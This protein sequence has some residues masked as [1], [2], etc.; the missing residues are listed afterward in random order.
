MKVSVIVPV[1]NVEEYLCDCIDSVIN[2]TYKHFELILVDDGS[3]DGSGKICD[4][5]KIRHPDKI[6]VI[7]TQNLGPIQARMHGIR[8]SSGD[9]LVFLD[10]DDCLR[11]DTLEILVKC[12]VKQECDMVLYDAMICPAFPSKNIEY[13]FDNGI[14]FDK[15]SKEKLYEKLISRQIPNSVCL[16]AIR[17]NL[18]NLPDF[19]MHL[20]NVKHGEDLLMS[21]YFITNCEKI[22]YLKQGLYHYRVRPGS[23]VHS[24]NLQRAE[25]IKTVHTELEKC[26]DIWGLPELKP[27][28]NARK[29]K[30]WL[31]NFVLLL[32]NK[33]HMPEADFRDQLKRM[34]EDPYFRSAYAG[35]DP[36][37]LSLAYR[38]LACCLIKKQYFILSALL[39]VKQSTQ[40]IKRAFIRRNHDR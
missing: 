22:V 37:K 23:A 25:S 15:T 28:H 19:F 8:N 6:V 7:H 21:A 3:T 24:F 1:Y 10:S 5:R 35:M 32:T 12:F 33:K 20:N 30:G 4:N 11:V 38:I 40:K 14:A 36:T 34:A 27:V 13:P 39:F 29:V 16:K 26:I 31:E 18:A 9:V 17:R 2:Q